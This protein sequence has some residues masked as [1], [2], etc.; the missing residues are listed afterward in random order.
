MVNKLLKILP[1]ASLVGAALAAAILILGS[2][3]RTAMLTDTGET[4]LSAEASLV[5]VTSMQPAVIDDASFQT[6][7]KN[8]LDAPYIATVWLV[9]P[10]GNIT[11]SSGST[12]RQGN[13]KEAATAE[14]ETVLS[15]L[16][17]DALSPEQRLQLWTASVIQAEGEHNDVYDHLL[18][19][20]RDPGGNLVA[21]VGVAYDVS[22]GISQINTAWIIEMLA[23]VLGLAVYWLSFPLWVFLDARRRGEKAVVWAVFVL[24]GNLAALIAYLLVRAPPR[25]ID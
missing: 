23:L 1:W 2:G 16:P 8:L 10:D 17:E 7:V 14:M 19:E 22:L 6:A 18:R 25:A 15:A 13:V 11:Y 24:L 3:Q 9:D 5:E 21:L 4:R 12:A 20:V